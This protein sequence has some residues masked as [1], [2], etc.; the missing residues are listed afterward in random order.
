MHEQFFTPV[1]VASA[2]IERFQKTFPQVKS[3]CHVDAGSGE[4]AFLNFLQ[5]KVN[6]IGVELDRALAKRTGSVCADFL[7]WKPAS[8]LDRSKI[9]VVTNPPF[10]LTCRRGRH[11]ERLRNISG[12]FHFITHAF[13]FCDTVAALLPAGFGKPGKRAQIEKATRSSMVMGRHLGKVAFTQP[14]GSKTSVCVGWFVFSRVLSGCIADELFSIPVNNHTNDFEFLPP[15]M[16]AQANIV[17]KRWGS[18]GRIESLSSLPTSSH[19]NHGSP[20]A[21]TMFWVKV[22]TGKMRAFKKACAWIREHWPKLNPANNS[23]IGMHDFVCV[24]NH[25]NN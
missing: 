18:V 25:V 7:K 17:V 11:G 16:H 3:W 1:E 20:T 5:G 14:D 8:T 23:N 9:V 12:S 24:Y 10:T 6:V 4:G 19:M 2:C 22:R 21:G 15:Y 13:S